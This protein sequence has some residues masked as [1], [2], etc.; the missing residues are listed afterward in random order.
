MEDIEGILEEQGLIVTYLDVDRNGLISL[1]ELDRAIDETTLLVSIMFA[2]NETGTL[3]PIREIGALAREQGVLFHTDAV[4]GVGKTARYQ[5]Y[6]C[7][8]SL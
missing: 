3:Q 4:Q 5:P 6:C 8:P 2:N 7:L 1:S